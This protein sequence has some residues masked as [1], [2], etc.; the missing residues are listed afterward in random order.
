MI[1]AD[2]VDVMSKTSYPFPTSNSNIKRLCLYPVDH[3]VH[4]SYRSFIWQ[5]V[6]VLQLIDECWWLPIE[7]S[8]SMILVIIQWACCRVLN[9]VA[10]CKSLGKFRAWLTTQNIL[11]LSSVYL[12][13]TYFG[14]L[15]H[16]FALIR[17][18]LQPIAEC[19]VR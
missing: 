15:M 2:Q 1:A 10:G 9:V 16:H 3:D 18:L 5:G 11:E 12:V 7:G 17:S 19:L 4:S 14:L 6:A 13:T 8:I